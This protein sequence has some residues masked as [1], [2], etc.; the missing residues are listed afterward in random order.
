MGELWKGGGVI[1]MFTLLFE[2]D[3][4]LRKS[5]FSSAF[6]YYHN[7]KL[8]KREN[9][10]ICLDVKLQYSDLLFIGLSTKEISGLLRGW[11]KIS[12]Q[13]ATPKY[14]EENKIVFKLSRSICQLN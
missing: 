14:Y 1:I 4:L 12:Y 5:S 6:L 13:I 10:D 11:N 8:L 2:D 3:S 9:K 7:L